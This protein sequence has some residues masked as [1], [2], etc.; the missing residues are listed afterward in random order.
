MSPETDATTSIERALRCLNDW[1]S[2]VCFEKLEGTSTHLS[3]VFHYI[4]SATPFALVS[5]WRPDQSIDENNL[6]TARL[7]LD[8]R[9]NEIESIQLLGHY[10]DNEAAEHTTERAFFITYYGSD[11]ERYKRLMLLLCQ[12]YGQDAV[13]VYHH[14]QIRVLDSTGKVQKMFNMSTMEPTHLKRIWSAMSGR[15]FTWLESGFLSANPI[16]LCG[17][18]YARVGLLSDIPIG[19]AQRRF[20]MAAGLTRYRPLRNNKDADY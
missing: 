13:A 7:L 16:F 6:S 18:E 3:R 15:N 1:T 10:D 17:P 8:L 12:K 11:A 4:W 14:R 19:S 20:H 9:D 5:A 2:F